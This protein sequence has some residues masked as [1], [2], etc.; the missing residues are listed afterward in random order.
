VKV[1]VD[2]IREDVKKDISLPIKQVRGLIRKVFPGV[3]PKYNKLWHGH[4]IVIFLNVWELVWFICFVVVIVRS[5]CPIK[6]RK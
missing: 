2:I 1:I 5:H 6:S 4:E 3:N